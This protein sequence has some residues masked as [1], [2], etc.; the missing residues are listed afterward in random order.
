MPFRDKLQQAESM[1]Y[2]QQQQPSGFRHPD[3]K[4]GG[5]SNGRPQHSG[6]DRDGYPIPPSAPA[7]PQAYDPNNFAP[8]PRSDYTGSRGGYE[9]ERASARGGSIDDS[10]PQAVAP[11][12]EEKAWANYNEAYGPPGQEQQYDERQQRRPAPPPSSTAGSDKRYNGTHARYDDGGRSRFD[13][14]D[15]RRR[16]QSSRYDDDYDDYDRERERDRRDR[17]PPRRSPSEESDRR[18]RRHRSSPTKTGKTGKDFLG[19]S[20][21]E[22]GLGAT[23]LGG[24]A[25]AFLGDQADKGM[26]GTVGGAVLGALAAKAGEK[27]M[28]KR[29]Q[30]KEAGGRRRGD[31]DYVGSPDSNYGGGGGRRA[32]PSDRGSVDEFRPRREARGP[33]RRT[34]RDDDSDGYYS[35]ERTV[36]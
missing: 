5:H 3:P 2:P 23:L 30:K 34:R 1:A 31:S 9:D 21:S 17:P 15:D 27:Q 25:G 35:D 29:Q 33:E 6:Y 16:Q 22:R 11:Y 19:Q 18:L 14:R 10:N 36:R 7:A 28:D 32:A 13:D 26:L 20:D 24:A 4:I 12:E 8:P